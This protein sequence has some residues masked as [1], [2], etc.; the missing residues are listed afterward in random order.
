MPPMAGA[1]T[2]TL[3]QRLFG[4]PGKGGA[5]AVKAAAPTG[6][7]VVQAKPGAVYAAKPKADH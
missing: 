4:D 7:R 5:G 3:A 2:T 6:P 1:A